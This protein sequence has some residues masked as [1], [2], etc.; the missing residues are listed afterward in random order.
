[1]DDNNNNNQRCKTQEILE[2]PRKDF[3]DLSEK[4]FLKFN[5]TLV[6]LAKNEFIH[7]RLQTVQTFDNIDFV[8][9]FGRRCRK[10][11]RDGK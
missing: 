5:L 10:R 9:S 7:S 2:E 3:A 6:F 4:D 11:R 8:G 1:M